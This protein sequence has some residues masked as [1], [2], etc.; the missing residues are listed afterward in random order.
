MKKIVISAVA[1]ATLSLGTDLYTG[2]YLSRTGI[3]KRHIATE[4]PNYFNPNKLL[5]K[6]SAGH[7]SV[8]FK[9]GVMTQESQ[10][11]LNALIAEAKER[12][13]YVTVIGHTSSFTE[14]SHHVELDGWSEFW[15]GLGTSLVSKS[16]VAQE[17]NSRIRHVYDYIVENGVAERKIYNENRMDRDPLATEATSAGRYLNERVDVAIYY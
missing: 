1:V 5:G 4:I 15:Q 14:L 6:R 12:G 17:V 11:A 16:T 13:G 2:T 8:Y 9:D 7:L 10:D 3:V